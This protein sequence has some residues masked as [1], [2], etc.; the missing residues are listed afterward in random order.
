MRLVEKVLG[1]HDFVEIRPI[2]DTHIGDPLFDDLLL[3]QEIDWVLAEDF[4]YLVLNGDIMNMATK[5]SV[6]NSYDSVMTPHEELKYA[7]TLFKRARKKILGVTAGNHEDRILKNDGID[8]AEELAISLG[9]SYCRE[10]LL[11][12]IKF[13]KR[14]TNSKPQVYTF[15]MTHGF[16]GSRTVGGK[17]NRLEKLRKIVVSDVYIVSHSHQKVFFKKKLFIPDLRNNKITEKIQTFINTGAYLRYGKYGQ[18]KSYDPTDLG[19][20]TIRLYAKEKNITVTG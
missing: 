9:T 6:S 5:H 8:I 11:L 17:A 16:T 13:G 1:N 4:R 2:S 7:R 20:L 3:Q 18:R 15:Y 19:T 10:G 14:K 12:K